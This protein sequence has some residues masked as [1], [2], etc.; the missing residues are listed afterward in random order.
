M[1]R[2]QPAWQRTRDECDGEQ[3]SDAVYYRYFSTAAICIALVSAGA[4]KKAA[5]L[6]R[7]TKA[8]GTRVGARDE[9]RVPVALVL[10]QR[11]AQVIDAL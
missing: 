4:Q 9:T 8:F 5:G 2:R 11:F 3:I 1:L 7:A 6:L 10:R